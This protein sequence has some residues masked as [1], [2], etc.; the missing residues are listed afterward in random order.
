MAYGQNELKG[1]SLGYTGSLDQL[2][3]ILSNEKIFG[4]NLY[5]VGLADLT[6]KYFKSMIA[7]PGA[8]RKTLHEFA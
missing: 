1:I 5:E 6:L 8:V 7:A 4:V 3:N 2:K